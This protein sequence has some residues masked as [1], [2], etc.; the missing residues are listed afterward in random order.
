MYRII[1]KRALT[2]VTTLYVIDAPLVARRAQP[3][4]FVIV[5]LD[6]R[7]E[8]IPLT[9]ADYDR[10]R[11]T[12]TLVVQDVGKTSHC[13]AAL[14]TNDYLMDFVGPLGVPAELPESGTVACVGGGVGVAPIYPKVKALHDRGVRVISIIGARSADLVILEEEMRAVSDELHVCTDDGSKGYHGFV[15]GK[16]EELIKAGAKLD[17][18]IA[19]GPLPMMRATC[20][21]TRPYGLKT[22]VSLNPIMVDGTGMCGAC[23]VTIGGETKFCCV[24]GPM[25]DGHQVDFREAMRRGQM[26]LPEERLAM[27][28]CRAHGGDR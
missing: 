23:R 5:R 24:D 9:I 15:S 4:Q 6:E 11:G 28:R 22:W 25:F 1:E 19:V 12:V 20:E 14:R 7:G 3:G 8:R 13:M 27:E 17:E 18:V 10:E 2:P 16:L 21:T 26:Y